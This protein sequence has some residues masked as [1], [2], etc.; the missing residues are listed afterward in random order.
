MDQAIAFLQQLSDK[1]GATGDV[2]FKVYSQKIFADFL[3]WV[4]DR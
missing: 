3:S 1:L 4:F 2:L